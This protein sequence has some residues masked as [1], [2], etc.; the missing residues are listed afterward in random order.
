MITGIATTLVLGI[1]MILFIAALLGLFSVAFGAYAEHGLQ[2]Q[3]SAEAFKSISAAIRYHQLYAIMTAVVGLAVLNSEKWASVYW[4]HYSGYLFI[5]GIVLFS[6]GI[7]ASVLLDV[8][9]LKQLAPFGG[10]SLMLGWVA[11]T[12]F[13][14]K[15]CKLIKRRG[16][17]G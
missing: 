3:I 8:E 11:L 1:K 12:V 7:Y 5:A 10:W 15:N 9:Q 14:F 2:K 6:F 16:L 13:A 4:L 17:N